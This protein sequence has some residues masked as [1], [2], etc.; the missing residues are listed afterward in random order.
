[1]LR[2]V[3]MPLADPGGSDC[4]KCFEKKAVLFFLLK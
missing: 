1:M 4:L 2:N 3:L